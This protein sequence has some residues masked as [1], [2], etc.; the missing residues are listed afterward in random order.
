MT[1][2]EIIE[3]FPECERIKKA[4]MAVCVERVFLT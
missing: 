2:Q 3:A 1:N 4:D